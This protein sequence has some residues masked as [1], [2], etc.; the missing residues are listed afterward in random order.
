[1]AHYLWQSAKAKKILRQNFSEKE[2]NLNCKAVSHS[3]TGMHNTGFRFYN[4][5]VC[6][7]V[8]YSAPFA[9][10]AVKTHKQIQ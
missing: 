7:S 6:L 1:M 9:L 5:N 2:G 10:C 4:E 3:S 8:I